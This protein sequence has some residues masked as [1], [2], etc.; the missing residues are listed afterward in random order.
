MHLNKK[1][2]FIAFAVLVSCISITDV[3]SSS[4]SKFAMDDTD[5]EIQD[6][7]MTFP[8]DELAE[9]F[10]TE[11]KIILDSHQEYYAYL[12]DNFSLYNTFYQKLIKLQKYG[13]GIKDPSSISAFFK[14][15][16]L[17]E[18]IKLTKLSCDNTNL[19]LENHLLLTERFV[20]YD[21]LTCFQIC[22]D[23]RS[24]YL[25][26][27][28]LNKNK[29]LNG[30]GLNYPSTDEKHIKQQISFNQMQA[31]NSILMFEQL[32]K[33]L[34]D[35]CCAMNSKGE[36]SLYEPFLDEFPLL[37]KYILNQ[38]KSHPR[39]DDSFDDCSS[40]IKNNFTPVIYYECGVE[41]TKIYH[42][43]DLPKFYEE[44]S[45]KNNTPIYLDHPS[46]K[47]MRIASKKMLQIEKKGY[48]K[49]VRAQQVEDMKQAER[50]I[51]KQT[52]ERKQLDQKIKA[53]D[54][55]NVISI[56]SKSTK[57]NQSNYS[58]ELN[59]ASIISS[60]KSE[61]YV[62]PSIRIKE[63]TRGIPNPLCIEAKESTS[64]VLEE[65]KDFH[66]IEVHGAIWSLVC[67][68]WEKKAG[69]TYEDFKTLFIKLGGDI[70]ESTGSSHMILIYINERGETIK[71]GIWK[72][73][74]PTTE[75]GYH[76]MKMLKEYMEKCGLTLD[77][78][79]QF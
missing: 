52:L 67:D 38:I 43:N 36:S 76:S 11:R 58:E 33:T 44:Q 46:K 45:K 55:Q 17:E 50:E 19:M 34:K 25:K 14:D 48:K 57:N 5:R 74:Y 73:H 63:K 7:K 54:N 31:R 26:N 51:E 23:G 8:D 42:N 72:Y 65:K 16:D 9:E 15:M 75:F 10:E 32:N 71:G 53:S 28:F 68:F 18:S 49:E 21:L 1:I 24:N 22:L 56:K 2:S 13:S 79:R 78:I 60:P 3:H 30:Q 77:R 4:Y 66:I 12:K 41:K 37:K 47:Q 39:P 27:R 6:Y 62:P 69:F 35:L 64:I 40:Y 29:Y 61:K 20:S 70:D 59:E